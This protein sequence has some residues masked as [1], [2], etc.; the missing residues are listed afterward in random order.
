VQ[1]VFTF[2]TFYF[3]TN[4]SSYRWTYFYHDSYHNNLQTVDKTHFILCL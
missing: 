4:V 1:V 3:A 2:F